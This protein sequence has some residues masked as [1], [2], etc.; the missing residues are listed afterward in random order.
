MRIYS[1]VEWEA[2]AVLLPWS[3]LRSRVTVGWNGIME[4]G[5]A[6]N[7]IAIAIYSRLEDVLI[8]KTPRT[9]DLVRIFQF[10]L[11]LTWLEAP[12]FHFKHISIYIYNVDWLT[13]T[14]SEALTAIPL[15]LLQIKIHIYISE[16]PFHCIY[17]YIYIYISTRRL[18]LTGAIPPQIYMYKRGRHFTAQL[19][20]AIRRGYLPRTRT[21]EGR[22][23][24]N[25]YNNRKTVWMIHCNRKH[26]VWIKI[27]ILRRNR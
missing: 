4:G 15:Q 10:W 2:K 12:L 19:A 9:I 8:K 17:I 21:W 18:A 26:T 6:F 16:A 5:F 22:R 14:W 3:E 11:A 27:Y 1:L 13:L 20:R 23:L 7:W 24:N 25:Y